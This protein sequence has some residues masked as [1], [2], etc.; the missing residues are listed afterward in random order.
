MNRNLSPPPR[1]DNTNGNNATKVKMPNSDI[2]EKISYYISLTLACLSITIL[3]I[4][5]LE[6]NWGLGLSLIISIFIFREKISQTM[7]D[8]IVK[9]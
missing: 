6:K 3:L 1:S 7:A 2:K 9:Y 8:I 5:I 4:A